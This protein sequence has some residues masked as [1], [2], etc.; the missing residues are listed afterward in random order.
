M[1][2][3]KDDRGP[4]DVGAGIAGE[5][6]IQKAT[7]AF[8]VIGA[9]LRVARYLLN[10]PL[11]WDEAFV[12]VNFLRR[13]YL[14]LLKP[15][16]YGQV[17]PV[18]FLWAEL[19]AVK[20]FGFAEWS[21]RL[22]PLVC[23]LAGVLLFRVAAGLVLK[24]LPLLLAVAI[25]AV[26]FHPIR[27]AA[28]LKPYAGD[29]LAALVLLTPALAWWREP[30]RAFWLVWLACLTPFALAGSHPSAFVAG[31]VA[32][33]VAPAVARTGSRRVILAYSLFLMSTVFTF[34]GLFVAFTGAQAKAT[35]GT[36]SAQWGQGFAPVSNP[37]GLARW[38][39][40][41]HAGGMFA[42]PCGGE[43]GA[44]A[45]TLALFLVGAVVLWRRGRGTVAGLCIAPFLVAM[46]ASALKRYPYGGVAHGTAARVMQYLVP[47][48]CLLTGLGA[49]ALLAR[50]ANPGR[51]AR[52]IRLTLFGLLIVGVAPLMI[53][54]RRP[55]RSVHAE[56]AREFAR[57]FWPAV[58]RGGEA[59]CL[60]WDLGVG[61]WDSTDLNVAVYL[62]N[63]A[64]YSPQRRTL[65]TPGPLWS[66]A[67]PKRPLRCV[68]SLSE[69][70]D[71]R[72]QTRLGPAY[73]LTS[74]KLMEVNMT[75]NEAKSRV[76]H[77]A[78]YE[79]VPVEKFAAQFDQID[80]KARR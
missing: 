39:I 79:F 30:Q 35:L 11:W 18:L 66:D 7:A 48:I 69:P 16:D 21:L 24:G 58:C 43:G 28:D 74:R 8:V 29:L 54:A 68:L 33:G 14:D 46:V 5:R 75:D 45:G 71:A 44:S 42:Y 60:R 6:A 25:F 22:V 53:D 56:K 13:G 57:T 62:C 36:M 80:V 64:I 9:A 40:S 41:V 61:P 3:V 17:C 52:A 10:Y 1:A 67:S 63:Q 31:G 73:H 34:A 72:V 47:S 37:L 51:K 19:S 26:S 38:L 78:V 27:H 12:A 23:A 49:A 59:V 65:P 4:I 2:E 76:E 77:H 15:L 32:L 50:I 20:I 55:Y 70:D